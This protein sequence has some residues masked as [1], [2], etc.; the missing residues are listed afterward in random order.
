MRP[1]FRPKLIV[2]ALW[3]AFA[4]QTPVV[5]AADITVTPPSGS[6]FVVKDNTG[7]TD[8][9]RVQESGTVTIPGLPTGATSNTMTCFDNASGRLG[10]CAP[11][12]G[13]GPTGA[14]GATGPTGAT[15]ATGPTG[16]TGATGATGPAGASASCAFADFYALMPADN[17]A[18]V[19]VG[20]DVQF[21]QDG[22]AS[23]AGVITR[24]TA[25]TFNLSAIGTYQIMFQVSVDEPGQLALTLNGT[26]LSATV[27][28]RAT[29]TS[30]LVGIALV[31]T[32]SINSILTVRNPTGNST[33][34]TITPIAGGT[35]AV[36]AHLVITQLRC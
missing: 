11:G 20:A 18:T 24:L 36:S 9:L 15:G 32:N 34:L 2:A 19:G 29:G 12:V 27:V 17:S 10:P 8:R 28:G 21:P 16:A 26:E 7:V 22:P 25:S 14:T 33:A 1:S 5:I 3:L 35:H 31:T 13:T 23:G 4:L 6:G 30:Q